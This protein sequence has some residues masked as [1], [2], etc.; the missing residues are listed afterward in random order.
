MTASK[1]LE[2]LFRDARK[3]V[4]SWHAWQRSVDPQGTVSTF[5]CHAPSSM[6]EPSAPNKQDDNES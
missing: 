1:E 5:A 6:D 4:E 3:Q 2:T